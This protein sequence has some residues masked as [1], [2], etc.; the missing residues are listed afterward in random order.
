MKFLK[1]SVIFFLLHA[2]AWAGVHFY[3]NNQP[4]EI[5]VVVDT[6]FS[7]KSKFPAIR[8]WIDNYES[9]NRYKTILIGTDKASL[10]ELSEIQSKDMIFRTS[11]GKLQQDNLKRHYG[12]VKAAQKILLSDGSIQPDGWQT[13]EF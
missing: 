4:T 3:Q 8:E 13:I 9:Q 11:F 2:T 12:G 5:L 1:L 10:G 7:M 6:S